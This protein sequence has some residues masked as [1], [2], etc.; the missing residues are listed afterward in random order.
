MF[1][2]DGFKMLRKSRVHFEVEDGTGSALRGFEDVQKDT[3]FGVF[4]ETS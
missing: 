3:I 4:V 2:R 1:V